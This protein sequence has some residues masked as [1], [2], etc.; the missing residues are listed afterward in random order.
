MATHP[1]YPLQ[2]NPPFFK[3]PFFLEIQDVTTF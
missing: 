2:V 3:I 1:P